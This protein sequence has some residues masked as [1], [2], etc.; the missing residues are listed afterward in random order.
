LGTSSTLGRRLKGGQ[1]E[2][3]RSATNPRDKANGANEPDIDLLLPLL[4]TKSRQAP[5]SM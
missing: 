5:K 1:A 4:Q 3:A 2:A